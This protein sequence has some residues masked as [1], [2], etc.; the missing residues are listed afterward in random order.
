[1]TG[2]ITATFSL[3]VPESTDLGKVADAFEAYLRDVL[4]IPQSD[5][6]MFNVTSLSTSGLILD[7]R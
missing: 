5:S 7:V 6:T 1:M 3:E 4:E 2:A